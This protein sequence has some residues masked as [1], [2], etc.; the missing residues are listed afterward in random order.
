MGE[1]KRFRSFRVYNTDGN[2]QT[3]ETTV[4]GNDVQPYKVGVGNSQLTDRVRRQQY[5]NDRL[6]I[7]SRRS[8]DH[9]FMFLQ[10]A[11]ISIVAGVV[12]AITRTWE[13]C[14]VGGIILLTGY[15]YVLRDIVINAY[16]WIKVRV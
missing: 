16:H 9:L 12:M 6:L 7:H 14:V 3:E 2:T 1:S 8:Y 11:A 4:S 15:G 5:N 10:M 13:G